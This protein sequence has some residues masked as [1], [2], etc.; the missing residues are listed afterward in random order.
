MIINHQ[1]RLVFIHIPKCGGTSVRNT[2]RHLHEGDA[3]WD[4]VGRQPHPALGVIAYNHLPLKSIK[5]HFP[6]LYEDI[7][8][9]E[10]FAIVRD[11]KIRFISSVSEYLNVS[12]RIE[13]SQLTPQHFDRAATSACEYLL[14]NEHIDDHSFISKNR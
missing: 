12:A 14:K 5:D 3:I 10:S 13:A 2:L 11:P 8:N 1:H 6:K 9:Y 7:S 4:V